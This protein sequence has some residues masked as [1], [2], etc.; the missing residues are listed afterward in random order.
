MV[1]GFGEERE[2]VGAR[3]R[4]REGEEGIATGEGSGGDGEVKRGKRRGR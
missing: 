2:G 4:R 1:G 3:G